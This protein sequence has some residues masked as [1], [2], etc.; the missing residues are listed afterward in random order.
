L[1][2]PKVNLILP[3]A[4]TALNVALGLV[5]YECA[6]GV[7]FPREFTWQTLLLTTAAV[8]LITTAAAYYLV[9]KQVELGHKAE[10]AEKRVLRLAAVVETSDDAITVE[11]L[12][13]VITEWNVGAERLYG[14]GSDEIIGKS[15][16]ILVPADLAAESRSKIDELCAGK[17]IEPFDTI[18]RRKDG[19]L[20]DVAMTL[21]AVRSPVGKVVGISTIAY[22]NS[23]RKRL[24]NELKALTDELRIRAALAELSAAISANLLRRGEISEVLRT[25]AATMAT[26]LDA[27]RVRI[28]TFNSDENVLELQASVGPTGPFNETGSRVPLGTAVIGRIAQS[29][30]PRLSNTPLQE[31]L[32]EDLDV[33]EHQ[34]IAA[35][36]G[37]P[38]LIEDRL[39][40]AM[41]IHA[42]Q[43]FGQ[44][45][46][47]TIAAVANQIAAGIERKRAEETL[48]RAEERKAAIVQS[49]MDAIVTID[50]D[51]RVLGFNPAAENT[52][53]FTE[54]ELLGRPIADF[55]IPAEYRQ[56][57]ID[58]LARLRDGKGSDILN[59]RLELTGLRK[60]GSS[61][62][63]EMTV[64]RVTSEGASVYTAF[65]RDITDRRRAE[66]DLRHE[67]EI[68]RS[69]LDTDPNLIFVK[70]SQ[71]AFVLA[72]KAMAQM[73]GTTPDRMIGRRAGD[74]LPKPAELADFRR[75]EEE[76]LSTGR[77]VAL[78]ETNTLPG[79]ETRWFHTIKSPLVLADGTIHV[80]G[81]ATDITEQKRAE[82][83]KLDAQQRLQQVV[84]SS[85]AVLFT[86]AVADGRIAGI[87]W[88]SDNLFDMLGYR[89][90]EVN[91]EDW[92]L[93][94][95]HPNDRVRAIAEAQNPLFTVG[96]AAHEYR[97]QHK[98][99]EYRWTRTEIKLITDA[100]GRASEAVGSWTDVTERREADD[101]LRFAEARYHDIVEN[102]RSGIFQSDADG[103]FLTVNPALARIYGYDSPAELMR[104]FQNGADTVYADR[105]IRA[106]FVRQMSERGFVKAFEAKVVRKDGS[107]LWTSEH[108][109]AA[110]DENGC[111]ICYEGTVEDISERKQAE[112]ELR[113]SEERYRAL[114][115]RNPMPMWVYDL[116]TLAF[117]AVNAAAISH[118][119]YTRDQFLAMTVQQI[120][121][122]EEQSE[123]GDGDVGLAGR[124]GKDVPW[125]HRKKDGSIIEVEMVSHWLN[126][127]GR[128]ARM[129]LVNDVTQ[130]RQAEALRERLLAILEATTDLVAISQVEG[131]ALYINSAG[132]K[133]LG[134][135]PDEVVCLSDYRPESARAV[136]ADQAIPTALRDRIWSGETR[137]RSRNGEEIVVSQVL[138]AH[139]N[140]MGGLECLS[141]IARDMRSQ[142][143]LEDQFRQAQKM[144]AVGQLAGGVAHDFNNLLTVING[145]SEVLRSKFRPGDPVR[146]FAD[147]IHEAGA[148][149]TVL[150]RQL[151]AFSRKQM[152]MP[153]VLDL[154]DL[155]A[156]M[157]RMLS[158][159]I[160]EDIEL[161]FV[162][163]SKLGRVKV[164]PGQ[165][166]QVLMNLVVN[167][168]DAMPR[169]GKLTIETANV[170]LEAALPQSRHGIPPG[171]YARV[172]VSDTG[173]G[174]SEDI[175]ARIFEPFFT[176][177]GPEKGT[178]LGLAT[179]YGIVKQSGGSI[180]VYSEP[181]I[182][183]T[184]K[185]YLPLATEEPTLRKPDSRMVATRGTETV[186]VVEDEE[187]VRKLTM[188]VLEKLGYKVLEACNAGEAMLIC[189]Q[190]EGEIA[191]MVTDVVMPNMSGCQLAKHLA[192]G[193]PKMKVLYL[194]GYTDDAVVSHGV[195]DS[196]TPFLQKPYTSIALA[197]KV[198]E[199]IDQE[200]RFDLQSNREKVFG[201]NGAE[202][203]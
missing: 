65:M 79:G 31:G 143:H 98:N 133:L 134:I 112:E 198:R 81:I 195:I 5:L 59:R 123:A 13:G 20:V 91:V 80:L 12:D 162:P 188:L 85:P 43:P 42:S 51:G 185:I 22:D 159:L 94:H 18:R 64:T 4:L 106:E 95:I 116:E 176:T 189:Q 108:A 47:D 169:G 62:P 167:A 26:H 145:Y 101:A 99:G 113:R 105:K 96:R 88:I 46:S 114:F 107:E 90:S 158:R 129:V 27:P 58:G 82:R 25:C 76:V 66:D 191:L 137:L 150:T 30:K 193:R 182:G 84:A 147:R 103:R 24:E 71:G 109:R 201:R 11:T 68:V 126:F 28:W 187:D 148:R 32:V 135:G 55:I 44:A 170:D 184:F 41:S 117:L 120:R 132:R 10:Q 104:A 15:S 119:G 177:K 7:L 29:R 33:A 141:T 144:E 1:D 174:M 14:Y 53:G 97:F 86:L 54:A 153:I 40:G 115:E 70:D 164:D 77:T 118:Y 93:N 172:A 183:T 156:D 56:R 197:Q 157:E 38:L 57:H 178:G 194:S 37:Y 36:A 199:V 92:W 151:L 190:H 23:R 35:F 163:D 166:E 168:R 48:R 89:P 17:R 125:K 21:S 78:D 155:I 142:K 8:S 60:N 203:K 34:A 74:G 192:P 111:F 61:F 72:N 138:I 186:L 181:G 180:D 127:D 16:S 75:T 69:V 131:P 45:M 146:E 73:Y 202:E 196:D 102:A 121:S 179:A 130:R 161:R 175:R 173:C 149:A 3:L 49:S 83:S 2:R 152:L 110:F 6:R 19:V 128:P 122:P 140:A 87:S 171:R 165:M 200:L 139:R 100:S 39:V 9:R 160:G 52:F 136:I 154:N 67:R 124:T 63:V 50:Q